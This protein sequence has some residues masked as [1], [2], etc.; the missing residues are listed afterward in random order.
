MR[1]GDFDYHLPPHLIA[2][3]TVEPR[4][5]SRLLVLHRSSGALEHRSFHDLG[6]YLRKGDLLVFNDS[7]V[8][9]ARVLARREETGGK[10]EFLLLTRL[11]PG[12]WRAIGRPGR[13]LRLGSRFLAEGDPELRIEVVEAA[14][15]GV[16]TVRLSRDD[17]L[18]SAGQLALP[19]YIHEPLEDP[20]RYQTVYSRPPGSVAAPTAG[21]HFTSELLEALKAQ[22]VLQAFVTLHVGLDT[23]RPVQGDYPTEHA[24]HGEYYELG[25]EAA[26][27]LNAARTEGRR[28]VAVGTT[29]VRLLEQVAL[30]SE[31]GGSSE[32]A[33]TAGWADLYILSGH[34][35]RVVDSMVTNF[36]LPR[37]T[38]LML[39]SAFAGR[40]LVLEVYR[41]AI[42]EGYRFYSF[43]DVMLIL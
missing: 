26:A 10:A 13:S 8:V 17:G 27:E 33:P 32:L 14:D 43:G 39:V 29:C 3:T 16:R 4:D 21:L 36:H 30:R 1:T 22:G 23:F 25:E 2:Q 20:E 34:R 7:R 28:V 35:F 12:I 41:K 42:E 38:L 9:P 31:E 37:T 6:E 40:K 18:D 15:N 5:S 19:P 11:E 24:I